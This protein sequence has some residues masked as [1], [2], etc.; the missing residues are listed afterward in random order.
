MSRETYLE[1][2]S[3]ALAEPLFKLRNGGCGMSIED[4]VFT[5]AVTSKS[6]AGN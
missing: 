5:D 2:D 1:I 3:V 4:F 6:R